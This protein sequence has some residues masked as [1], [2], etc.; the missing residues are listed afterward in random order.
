MVILPPDTVLSVE[1]VEETFWINEVVT[2][3]NNP[4]EQNLAY[5]TTEVKLYTKHL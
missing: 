1:G 5:N 3:W 2:A 4:E